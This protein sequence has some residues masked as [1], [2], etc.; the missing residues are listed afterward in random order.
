MSSESTYYNPPTPQLGKSNDLRPI[1]SFVLILLAFLAIFSKLFH[2]QIIQGPEYVKQA[3][4]NT[5][6]IL[7]QM[8]PRGI[9]YDREHRVL[10]SNKQ[11]PS[12]VILPSVILKRDLEKISNKLGFIL[13]K[14]PEEIKEKLLKLD[15][16][17]SRPFTLQT[18]LSLKQ[19]AAI[20]ENQYEL[21]GV[22]VQQQSARH[23]VNGTLLS[24]VL[25]YTGKISAK[26]L[27]TYKNKKM[28]DVIGKYGIEKIYDELLRGQDAYKRI[29]VNRIGQPI[30]RV[31]LEDVASAKTRSGK[32]IT[33]T[34][35]LDLQQAAEKVLEEKGFR[36]AIIMIDVRSGEVLALVSKPDF[37]PNVFTVKIPDSM[38]REIS[39]KKIFLNR[40]ISSYPPG[41]IW[42]PVVLLAALESGA[43]KPREKFKVSG[44]FYLG[45]TRFGDWTNKRGVFT[46]Q[47]SLAW[48]RDTAFYQ[49]AQRMSDEDI[50]K[51]GKMFGAGQATGLELDNESLGIVPDKEWKQK[52]LNSNWYPGN[53]LHY[54]I[55]QG[56]LLMTPAQAVRMTAGLANET[57]LPK[58]HLIKQIDKQLPP[59]VTHEPIKASSE[60]LKIVKEGMVECVE[61]GTCQIIKMPNLTAAGKTGS[62]E[63]PPNRKTHGWFIAYAPKENPEIAIAAFAEAAGHG[64]SVAAPMAKE[65]IKAY[66]EKYHGYDYEEEQKKLWKQQAE[67]WR[68]KN[69]IKRKRKKI[70]IFRAKPK[71]TIQE[72]PQ[73]IDSVEN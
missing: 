46:L 53:T 41:S 42:K 6:F 10:A 65:V 34:I 52:V 67:R 13:N 47:K 31:N 27:E 1:F 16:D 5:T 38:W 51:W 59:K 14:K 4:E 22:T 61:S 7:T 30:E 33:L 58:L 40:A 28:H 72:S 66:F 43:V 57:Y 69:R 8:A 17:D 35:D 70:R 15:E 62:A 39:T 55:G 44:A 18:K 68:R 64:G 24:H 29:R 50:T 73:E 63:A 54:S 25:G 36:G 45:R 12:I 26:E 11:T 32:D 3:Q 37:D 49:M 19:V 60:R 20:Y 2:L 56:Y 23:Y 48:S 9:I 71:P 21:P